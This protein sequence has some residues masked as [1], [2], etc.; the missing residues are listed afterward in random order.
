[1]A[2]LRYFAAS[3]DADGRDLLEAVMMPD[4]RQARGPID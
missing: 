2:A 4:D 1:V 3:N